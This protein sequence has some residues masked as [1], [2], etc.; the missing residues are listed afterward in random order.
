MDSMFYRATSFN[1]P[2]DRWNVSNVET[3]I[4]MF[5]NATSF[6]Q[7]SWNA[8]GLKWLRNAKSNSLDGIIVGENLNEIATD[9]I[10]EL[11]FIHAPL[12]QKFNVK[13]DIFYT[14]LQNIQKNQR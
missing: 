5:S 10:A 1:Q 9:K 4:D 12:I 13:G 3:M 11:G 7:D 8:H 6:N 2:L 14:L